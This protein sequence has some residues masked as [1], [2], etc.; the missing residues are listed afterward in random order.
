MLNK[1]EILNLLKENK[2]Q[3]EALGA[4]KIGLFGSYAKDLATDDSDVDIL[5]ELASDG[6]I[7][8]NYCNIKYFLEDLF[9]KKI[10]LLTTSHFR[11]NYKTEIG[12]KHSELIQKEI[13]E[14]I[15][16]V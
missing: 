7:Y 14:S 1:I 3:I 13:A 8:G 12:K 6:D 11:K 16:Y 10:D 4:T 5:I 15:I 2:T 9:Q